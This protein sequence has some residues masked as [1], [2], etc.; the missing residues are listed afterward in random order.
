MKASFYTLRYFCTSAVLLIHALLPAQTIPASPGQPSIINFTAENYNASTQNWCV[1]QQPGFGS[2]VVAN[3][4]GVLFYNGSRWNLRPMP[5]SPIVRSVA[6]A[7]DGKVYAG[8]YGKAGYWDFSGGE[9]MARYVPLDTLIFKKGMLKEEIWK[10]IPTEEFVLFQTFNNVFL[11]Y[12]DGSVQLIRPPHHFIFAHQVYGRIFIPVPG[13]GLYEIRNRQLVAVDSSPALSALRIRCM[14]PYR[15]NGM[16]LVAEKQGVWI[17][18][19]TGALERLGGNGG[20][21]LAAHSI[22]YGHAL[23]NGNY[24]F[25]SSDGGAIVIS[26]GGELL[27]HFDNSTGL[28]SNTNLEGMEDR[29]NNIWLVGEKGIDLVVMNSP[30]RLYT[31]HT[32]FMDA[33][34]WRDNIY[35]ATNFGLLFENFADW[36]NGRSQAFK[37]VPE[38]KEFIWSVSVFDDQLIVG[39]ASGTFLVKENGS[40][41]R[42]SSVS[43]GWTLQRL[44]T[45]PHY[46]IQG[47]YLGLTLFKKDDQGEWSFFKQIEKDI[48]PIKELAQ[49]D[50]GV[51][52]LKHAY[53]GLYRCRLG[54]G[55]DMEK[56]EMAANLAG[57]TVTPKNSLF[58]YDGKVYI[59]SDNGILKWEEGKKEIEPAPE[60]EKQLGENRKSKKIIPGDRNEYWIVRRSRNDRFDYLVKSDSVG[61][62]SLQHFFIHNFNLNYDYEK[63]KLLDKGQYLFFGGNVLALFSM[64]NPFR[65]NYLSYKP[66]FSQVLF[67]DGDKWNE[68]GVGIDS[69]V[70]VPNKTN[71]FLLRYA[72]PVF[73][74]D[75]RYRYKLEGNGLTANWSDWVSAGER[76]FLNMSP[77][78]Y[79]FTVQTDLVPNT[80]FTRIIVL[81]PWY[82]STW[83]RVLYGVLFGLGLFLLLRWN[84]ARVR[85]RQQRELQAMTEEVKRQ[86]EAIEREQAILKKEQLELT[87]NAKAREGADSAMTL[88]KKNEFLQKIRRDL[89]KI[90]EGNDKNGIG[91]HSDRLIKMIDKNIKDEEDEWNLFESNFNQVHEQFYKKLLEAYPGLTPND[92][93]FAAYLKMNLSSKEIAPLLNITVKSLE[94]K[95]HRLRRKM[96]LAAVENLNEVLMKF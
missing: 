31:T 79:T 57:S 61:I 74:R 10:I 49:D 92:L 71:Y 8:A 4:S 68:Q 89:V 96:N 73:D 21:W 78:A 88:I 82:W 2:L 17:R 9:G 60:I 62:K 33:V 45:D 42:I 41:R 58:E 70:T 90:K 65:E 63:I 81:P 11:L 67:R 23:K 22:S 55:G 25:G 48:H 37:P 38:L 52:Y 6:A 16:L 39:S 95:R 85:A 28:Q 27:E 7:P 12:P 15:G 69:T 84:A 13:S 24:L 64:Q 18:N 76:E 72:F 83:A 5:G 93:K 50:K 30:F 26:D 47:N 20:A 35:F 80:L 43:G 66:Y 19:P 36:K 51:I 56:M 3:S 87:L 75:V 14:L 54:A 40:V 94:L 46:L 53:E 86:Q 44:R 29:D 32:K 1:A 77:G 59:T 34:V 91:G